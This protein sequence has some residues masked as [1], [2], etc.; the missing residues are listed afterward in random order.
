VSGGGAGTEAA[1]G[2][3]RDAALDDETAANLALQCRLETL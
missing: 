2:R 1:A 3:I